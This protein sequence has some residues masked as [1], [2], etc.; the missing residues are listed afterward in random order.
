M[1]DV[2]RCEGKTL[3]VSVDYLELPANMPALTGGQ[4]TLIRHFQPRL[5]IRLPSIHSNAYTI[6]FLNTCRY[7]SRCWLQYLLRLY[8]KYSFVNFIPSGCCLSRAILSP[9]GI[10]ETLPLEVSVYI[11]Q[12]LPRSDLKNVRLVNRKQNTFA[13]AVLFHTI[14]VL[15]VTCSFAR[16]YQIILRDHLAQYIRKL[17]YCGDISS[18]SSDDRVH[19][20]MVPRFR[21]W[22]QK[23]R[24]VGLPMVVHAVQELPNNLT[25]RDHRAARQGHHREIQTQRKLYTSRGLELQL[26]RIALASLPKLKAIEF[27]LSARVDD[28]RQGH[29]DQWLLSAAAHHTFMGRRLYRQAPHQSGFPSANLLAATQVA[30]TELES[31]IV[32]KLDLSPLQLEPA[33]HGLMTKAVMR[34]THLHLGI[35]YVKM[36]NPN[37]EKLDWL[38]RMLEAARNLQTLD[39]SFKF[40]FLGGSCG[41]RYG[42]ANFGWHMSLSQLLRFG[43]H[44]PQLHALRLLGLS[45]GQ[46]TLQNLLLKHKNTLWFL[47][48]DHIRLTVCMG[49]SLHRFLQDALPSVDAT[50]GEHVL[51]VIPAVFRW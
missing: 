15:P 19:Q 33:I 11:Y 3:A 42:N 49:V 20:G 35:R 37:T 45:V 29:L 36:S 7:E 10:M 38:A 32:T 5:I 27:G 31:I 28:C 50:I 48:L 24:A 43:T 14:L 12:E 8:Q 26:F 41:Y 21:T 39:L 46:K 30:T 16:A 25:R 51:Y 1:L 40:S 23:C 13:E 6:V 22:C 2:L 44:W 34:T 4:N 17:V 9:A 47:E 18:I